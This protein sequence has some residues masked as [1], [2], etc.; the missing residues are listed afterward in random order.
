MSLALNPLKTV[1]VFD[2]RI[3]VE[4]ERTWAL[5]KGGSVVTQRQYTT[6]NYSNQAFIFSCPPPSL[7]VF[8]DRDVRLRSG[9]D[10]SFTGT[11]TTDT[12]LNAGG[13]AFRKNPFSKVINNMQATINTSQISVQIGDAI[14]GL[15][16]AHAY[17][18]ETEYYY[19][20]T[21]SYPDMSQSYNDLAG[22][23]RNP[24]GGYDVGMFGTTQRGAFP[25]VIVSNSDTAAEVT[26]VI[27]EPIYMSPFLWTHEGPG[28]YNVQTFDFQFNFSSNL[29][30]IW[31]HATSPAGP[32]GGTSTISS[33][34]VDFT[35]P[36][37]LFTYITP[38][39]TM[40]IP[41][42]NLVYPFYNVTRYPNGPSS[43]TAGSTSQIISSTINI[44][45]IPKRIYCFGM[46]QPT[47]RNQN[48]TD[49]FGAIQ[50]ISIQFGNVSN[51]L[52]TAS[53]QD[54]Y[55]M[56]RKNGLA[57]SWTEFSGGY[58]Y[59]SDFSVGAGF[60]TVG[61]V[62]ILEPG[63]DFGLSDTQVAG[64][65]EKLTIQFNVT[66]KNVSA[67]TIN[68]TLYIVTIDDGLLTI[69]TP[70]QSFIQIGVVSVQDIINS[71]NSPSIVYNDVDHLEGG[72]FRSN[73]LREKIVTYFRKN[74][75][76]HLK[77]FGKDALQHA[78]NSGKKHLS[79]LAQDLV[80]SSMHGS[81]SVGGNLVGGR[82]MS[83]KELKRRL[84]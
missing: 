9:V 17:P 48:T 35:A 73:R 54:L 83:R 1:N 57:M 42:Q 40:A 72:D 6:T 5:V 45:T 51:L 71:V 39:A 46:R 7:D 47:D 14:P 4:N 18:R 80:S 76:P 3:A 67:E 10:A 58:V 79:E 20:M 31:S 24:L 52:A 74:I 66:L 16:R 15:E 25:M 33:I 49:T 61:S 36:V 68:Y 11:A 2:P 21:P 37:L 75:V 32:D 62:V 30:S 41:R 43:I 77:D 65:N 23:Q 53:Q 8:V 38:K 19:G 70:G 64:L 29:S 60:G 69:P 28:L 22:T 26:A 78:Y 12:L 27:T 50:N 63:K 84:R 81:A 34:T 56:S 44:S 59:G 82:Q 55:N 13:D